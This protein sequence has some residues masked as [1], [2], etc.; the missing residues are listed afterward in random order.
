[1]QMW[2]ADGF[3]CCG[4]GQFE[5]P[6]VLVKIAQKW[7]PSFFCSLSFTR[8][9]QSMSLLRIGFYSFFGIGFSV[10]SA[11]NQAFRIE[12]AQNLPTRFRES[13]SLTH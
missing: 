6:G 8:P 11:L 2:G 1:M 4:D 12:T 9:M 13:F 5:R 3:Q 7:P 10:P